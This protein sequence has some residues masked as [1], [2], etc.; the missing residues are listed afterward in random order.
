MKLNSCEYAVPMWAGSTVHEAGLI[1]TP[2]IDAVMLNV[3][4]SVVEVRDVSTV[5]S[6]TPGVGLAAV[7][8]IVPAGWPAWQAVPAVQYAVVSVLSNGTPYGCWRSTRTRPL[9]AVTSTLKAGVPA[10]T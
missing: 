10:G 8:E 4:G 5:T 6:Q 3:P 7:R 9:V 2:R 1:T